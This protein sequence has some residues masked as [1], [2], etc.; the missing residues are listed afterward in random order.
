MATYSVLADGERSPAV[1]LLP[2]VGGCGA[3]TL[4]RSVAPFAE[5]DMFPAADD[6]N[7]VVVVTT[8]TYTGVQAAHRIIQQSNDG[9]GGGCQLLGLVVVNTAGGKIP[10]PVVQRLAPVESKLRHVWHV[11]YVEEWRCLPTEQLPV[12]DPTVSSNTDQA[13]GARR[14]KK[15][16]TAATEVPEHVVSVATEICQEAV[17]LYQAG[18]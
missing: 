1:F 15:K 12:W 4:A 17:G 10:K 16:T 7:M 13:R 5:T 8:A 6:P 11:D 18:R 2:A 14:R 9:R 3:S